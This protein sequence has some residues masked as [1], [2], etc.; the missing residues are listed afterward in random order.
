MF[1]GRNSIVAPFEA[2]VVRRREHAR[3]TQIQSIADGHGTGADDTFLGAEVGEE[4]DGDVITGS[5]VDLGEAVAGGA[6]RKSDSAVVGNHDAVEGGDG[7]IGKER[8][9]ADVVGSHDG[10]RVRV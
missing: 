7:S 9:R 2:V 1:F 4:R 3:G 6:G 8:A 10:L 5:G